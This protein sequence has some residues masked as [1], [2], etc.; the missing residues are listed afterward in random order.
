MTYLGYISQIRVFC[1]ARAFSKFHQSRKDHIHF[2]PSAG[3]WKWE[4]GAWDLAKGAESEKNIA[5]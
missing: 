3:A 1:C 2:E 4:Q 5:L